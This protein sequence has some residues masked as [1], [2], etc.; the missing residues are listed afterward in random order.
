M[1]P[2]HRLLRI[3]VPAM[4]FGW[5]LVQTWAPPRAAG[6]AACIILFTLM[7]PSSPRKHPGRALAGWIFL[8][9]ILL[10]WMVLLT[11]GLQG[12]TAFAVFVGGILLMGLAF[13]LIYAL[14]FPDG[15][16]S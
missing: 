2:E 16:Q 3:L 7:I 4:A 11:S 9:A 13:P 8:F 5:L 12:R 15:D 1:R 14:S 10:I 6:I